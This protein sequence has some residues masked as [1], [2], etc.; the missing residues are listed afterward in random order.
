MRCEVDGCGEP[1]RSRGLCHKHYERMRRSGTTELSPLPT[2][3]ERFVELTE[4]VGECLIWGG[5]T[6]TQGYGLMWLE[7]RMV[8][9]HRYAWEIVNGP[10]PDA[11]E[12]DHKDHCDRRCVE[13]DHLRLATRSQNSQN[14]SGAKEGSATGVRNVYPYGKRFQVRVKKGGKIRNFGVHATIGEARREAEKAR[15]VMFGEFAGKGD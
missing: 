1:R 2:A 15:A 9:A 10:I 3:E 8:S 6:S 12:I 13:A 14:R 5:G 4:R 7:G 11:A